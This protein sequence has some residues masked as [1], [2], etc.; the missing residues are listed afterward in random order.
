MKKR[1]LGKWKTGCGREK[2][3]KRKMEKIIGWSVCTLMK[4]DLF[5]AGTK[6]T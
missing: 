4:E 3:E 6:Y 1:K 2:Q 5:H